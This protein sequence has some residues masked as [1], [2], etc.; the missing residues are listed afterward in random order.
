MWQLNR[1]QICYIIYIVKEKGVNKMKYKITLSMERTYEIEA[2]NKDEAI[3]K[4][5]ENF[6]KAGAE[7]AVEERKEN[8]MTVKT[9]K[10]AVIQNIIEKILACVGFIFLI[11]IGISWAGV[12]GQQT[13]PEWNFF[14]IM[15]ELML[16]YR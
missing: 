10:K 3:Y 2:D 9:N 11:W 13:L 14:H 1:P 5:Y 7:I 16:Q 8:K 6:A 15:V 12:L 4:A